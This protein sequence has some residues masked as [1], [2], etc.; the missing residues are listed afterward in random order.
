[1]AT[2]IVFPASLPWPLLAGHGLT[3]GELAERVDYESGE[4]RV[5]R[6]FRAAPKTATVGWALQQDEFDTF[7]DWFEGD[8]QVGVLPFDVRLAGQG[9]RWVWWTAKFIAPYAWSYRALQGGTDGLYQVDAQLLLLGAPFGERVLPPLRARPTIDVDMQAEL[10]ATYTLRSAFTLSFDMLARDLIVTRSL[11]G[12]FA[13]DLDLAALLKASSP[14]RTAFE[15]E[16]STLAELSG[17]PSGCAPFEVLPD[18]G[19]TIGID[20]A[21]VPLASGASIEVCEELV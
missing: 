20:E 11:C 13:I 4:Q 15:I 3:E 12:A 17:V 10:S 1:M 19:S 5:R 8:L 6:M 7:A 2:D 21:I 18:S 9:T 16:V 14:L